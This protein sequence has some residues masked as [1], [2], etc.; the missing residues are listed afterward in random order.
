[1]REVIDKINLR[2][3]ENKEQEAATYLHGTAFAAID[4]MS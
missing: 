1:M 4:T 2:D 3:M